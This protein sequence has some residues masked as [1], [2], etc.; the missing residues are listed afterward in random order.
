M[1]LKE[2]ELFEWLK[3]F[4]YPDLAKSESK[5]ATFDCISYDSKL[6]IELKTRNT[7]YDELLIEQI[8][9]Q[10]IK[11]AASFLEMKPVY[12]NCTPAGIYSFDLS[13]IAEPEWQEKW[14]PQNTEFSSRGNKT[15]VVGFIHINQ[16][17][18]L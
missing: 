15:K 10:A 8:K 4:H 14:L 16:A 9:Y 13:K 1:I 17:E 12:I 2:P 5:F 11:D 3:E 6:Y 7:H 18:Q